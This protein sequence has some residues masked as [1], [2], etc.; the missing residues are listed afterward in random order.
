MRTFFSRIL[1]N[2]KM[3]FLSISIILFVSFIFG[4]IWYPHTNDM[5]KDLLEHV[6]YLNDS[7]Y[8]NQYILY[9][10]ENGLFIILSTYL[11]TS[12]IG[13]FGSLWLVFVKGIQLSYSLVFVFKTLESSFILVVFIFV[14]I[15]LELIFIYVV[16][17]M[18][19]NFSIYNLLITFYIKEN[20]EYK[21]IL[22]YIL[23][24]LIVSLVILSVLLM[25]RI[26]VVPVI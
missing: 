12:F 22:N 9:L 19:I 26:Y 8:Q 14:Q 15:L 7:N 23:N 20:F 4:F 21:L 5:F 16:S 13:Y 3:I 11:S 6:F 10:I 25:F 18:S 17:Y 1:D 2:R 24:F